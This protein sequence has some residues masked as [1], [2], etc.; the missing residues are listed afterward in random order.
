[1]EEQIRE[2]FEAI[3][4]NS[5]TPLRLSKRCETNVYYHV[6]DLTVES[7]EICAAY[8]SERVGNVCH[9]PIPDI[10]INLPGNYTG[11]A[12]VLSKELAAPGE[13]IEVVTLEQL[14]GGNGFVSRLKNSKVILV[15]DVIT[16]ARSCLK[17]HSRIT[18]MGA[19][20]LC[21]ATLIDR[22]FGPGP[23]PVISAYTGAPVTLLERLP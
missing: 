3:A 13:Q 4:E 7:I 18:M 19:S 22:T 9:P 11:L 10:I 23:V 8:I 20:I 16:T 2:I 17:A 15:N 12:E 14:D 1:M 21:W 6:E 5:T